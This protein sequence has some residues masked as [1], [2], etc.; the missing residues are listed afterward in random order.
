MDFM[1]IFASP[2]QHRRRSK[3]LG[4]YVRYTAFI[5]ITC[6]KSKENFP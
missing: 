2:P 4:E 6:F 5:K 3:I 1:V